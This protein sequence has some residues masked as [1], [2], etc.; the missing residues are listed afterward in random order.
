MGKT[1]DY[2]AIQTALIDEIHED[3][4]E[5]SISIDFGSFVSGV[6]MLHEK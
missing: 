3:L 5:G 2:S 6:N 1:L 4:V